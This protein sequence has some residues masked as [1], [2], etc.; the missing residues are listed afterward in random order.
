MR[1]Y[2]EILL[3]NA[4]FYFQKGKKTLKGRN[5]LKIL[6]ACEESQTVCAEMRKLG[7][8][9]YSADIQEPSG[10][11]PEWHILGDVLPLI[12]GK[13]RFTTMDGTAHQITGK[14]D[15]LIAHPPCTYLTSAGACRLMPKGKLDKSRLESGIAAK[16]FFLKF[17]YADCDKICIENPA[18]MK[19]YSLPPYSQIIQPYMFGENVTKRTCL[20]LKNLEP[21]VATNYIGRPGTDTYIRKNGEIGYKCWTQQLSSGKS[22][23]KTF[24]G[25]AQAMAEQ[26]CG[27]AQQQ[28]KYFQSWSG[29][30]DSTASIILEHIYGLPQSKIIM[31]EVMF[32]RKRN[33]S[34]ELPEHMEWVHNVAIPLFQNWGYEIEIVHADKDYLDL[35]YHVI[36]KSKKEE[37]NGKYAGFLIGGLCKTNSALK[38]KPINDFYNGLSEKYV[39]Y[40]GI[41]ADEPARLERLNGTNKV[42][43]LSKYGYTE[44]I[45]LWEELR[46]LSLTDNRV[47]NGFKYEKTFDEVDRAVDDYLDRQKL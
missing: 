38:T 20:W 14:W 16:E 41:A 40:V 46:M 31:S 10:G 47:S 8:E 24:P 34:G 32:D 45:E 26:W 21:L 13:C 35:F 11:H 15:L 39:Q 29:G 27:N 17:Y 9:A 12:N 7:H 1:I 4:H 36:S 42:S 25:I 3:F 28:V 5:N 30:K 37:R 33:I 2:C 44:Q 19:I 6:I 23:S 18:P 43:L 22:R